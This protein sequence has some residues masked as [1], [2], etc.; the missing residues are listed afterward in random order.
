[1]QD[2]RA[3]GT[4]N[5]PLPTQAHPVQVVVRLLRVDAVRAHRA[6]KNGGERARLL[7]DA[8]H[9]LR[10][11]AP[12]VARADE[13]RSVERQRSAPDDPAR[14][15]EWV[16]AYARQPSQQQRVKQRQRGQRARGSGGGSGGE[17]TVMSFGSMYSIGRSVMSSLGSPNGRRFISSAVSGQSCITRVSAQHPIVGGATAPALSATEAKHGARAA[18]PVRKRILIQY[19][20]DGC[21]PCTGHTCRS[22]ASARHKKDELPHPCR[23]DVGAELAPPHAL[24]DG[25]ERRQRRRP[26]PPRRHPSAPNSS[27]WPRT[28][29]CRQRPQN[30]TPAWRGPSAPRRRRRCC[31]CRPWRTAGPR[32]STACATRRQGPR[33][34][35]A[36]GAQ[37]SLMAA[38]AGSR[39]RDLTIP[40]R[41]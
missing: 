13:G 39:A 2:R 19:V 11:S 23:V 1:M 18:P 34:P 5:G 15:T 29:R 36:D 35:V 14:R 7:G 26:A 9:D 40:G 10:T 3:A 38:G 25:R 37:D 31:A 22:G 41:P 20:C 16:P 30:A 24:G 28:K 21:A 17:P 12:S 4:Q 32:W 6:G 8:V 33:P 27:A